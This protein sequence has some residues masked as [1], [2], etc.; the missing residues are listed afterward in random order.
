MPTPSRIPDASPPPEDNARARLTLARTWSYRLLSTVAI[1]MGSK[2]LD[3]ELSTRLD[4]LCV[5]LHEEPFTTVVV[6]RAGADLAR[7]G[8]LGR[9]G[10]K[11]TAEVLGKGL[12]A[13]PEFQPVERYAERIVL[14]IGAL[15][16]GFTAAN[17]ESVLA[18]Q[19]GMQRSLLK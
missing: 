11:C 9:D 3:A 18:Q 16:A 15:G 19:E 17:T 4:E 14:A 6:E 1:P 5:A 2:D 10:L 8:H 13:L 7:L 12:L